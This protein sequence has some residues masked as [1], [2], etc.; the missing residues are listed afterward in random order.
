MKFIW[1]QL[2]TACRKGNRVDGAFLLLVMLCAIAM[3][4][5]SISQVYRLLFH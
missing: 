2:K 4:G 3:T 5:Y 1:E